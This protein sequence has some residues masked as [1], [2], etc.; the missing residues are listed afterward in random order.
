[1][2]K[3][4][5]IVG[6]GCSG[7]AAIKSC[8]EEDLLPLC[9]ESS[10][11]I[12]GLWNFTEEIVDKRGC[13]MS[14][15]IIN[16]SKEMMAF[17]D[18]P[19][20]KEFPNFMPHSKVLEYFRLYAEKFQLL[21]HIRFNTEVVSI[22]RGE[23]TFPDKKLQVCE[24]LLGDKG[25]VR[26]GCCRNNITA[27][28]QCPYDNVCS[29]TQCSGDNI[30]AEPQCSGDNISAEPQCSD[31][32]ISAEPQCSDYNIS[33]EPQCSKD[34]TNA[35]TQGSLT[36]IIALS[37]CHQNNTNAGSQCSSRDTSPVSRCSSDNI[38]TVPQYSRNNIN[39]G[40]ECS[41]DNI[42]DTPHC[43]SDNI[44]AGL[45]CSNGCINAPPQC[46]PDLINNGPKRKE[47]SS[48]NDVS[49][50]GNLNQSR[51][52]DINSPSVARRETT[53]GFISY[54]KLPA[55]PNVKDPD[56]M[57][58]D[59]GA[60]EQTAQWEVWVKD[61]TK[62]SVAVYYFD[63]VLVCSGHHADIS[64]PD[65]PGQSTF[66]GRIIHS[67]DLRRANEVAGSRHVV[68]G[69]G[70]SGCDAAVALSGAGKQVY[71]STRRGTWLM[72]RL[73]KHGLPADVAYMNRVVFAIALR[74]PSWILNKSAELHL[75][76]AVDH[77]LYG[78]RPKHAPLATHPTVNDEL[79]NKI[80]CGHVILKP[81][82]DSFTE[83]GVK[84]GDGTV[85]D[86]V[87]TVVMAT[88]YKIGFPF[89]DESIIEVKGNQSPLYLYMFPPALTPPTLAVIGCVQAEG[90]LV[91][92]TEMQ[93]RVAVRVFTNNVKLPS[94]RQMMKD[95]DARKRTMETRYIHTERHTV[96]VSFLPYMDE[97]A[98]MVGCQPKI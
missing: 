60:S 17:S 44:S 33:A 78:L 15:T 12:G 81:D 97:L 43:S 94:Q 6:A 65:F 67:R 4:V 85:A 25:N 61:K 98:A 28:F 29:G 80:A 55:I 16:T 5:A 58:I 57:N 64:M 38:N 48:F 69:I 89:L 27:G 46:S 23:R 84:F 87:D 88:G 45:Q 76:K 9:F 1:M 49:T 14:S 68:V 30:S 41:S 26:T 72:Q 34:E 13:V 53:C 74:L 8:L 36:N 83:F 66:K 47:P 73:Q 24:Q 19:P 52:E 71:L 63:C 35:E 91:P 31:E 20:P 11:D 18:F 95:V 70:N 92:V 79:P 10:S 51:N 62:G 32:N 2:T 50:N 77:T 75:N 22:R 96:Q 90:A 3:R 39:A 7:L 42:N 93:C 59:Q 82:I 56:E 86:D 37:H 21:Q 40:I 54:P